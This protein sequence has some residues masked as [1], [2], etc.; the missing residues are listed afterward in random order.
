[1]PIDAEAAKALSFEP[2]TVNIERGRLRFFAKAT[3]QTDPL[4]TDVDAARRAGHRDLPVPPTFLFSLEMEQPE[5]FGY[6]VA[7]GVDLRRLL[8]GEQSFTYHR[9]AFAGDSLTLRPRITDVYSKKGGALEFLVKR[10]D[11]SRGGE[12]IAEARS[13]LIVRAAEVAA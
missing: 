10:T 13:V 8:H 3:G 9:P 2:L 11:I 12:P 1:M 5:P 6:L 4:Y 7:L